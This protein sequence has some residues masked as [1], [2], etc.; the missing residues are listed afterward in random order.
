MGTEDKT[1]TNQNTNNPV[2]EIS[3]YQRNSATKNIAP[4]ARLSESQN[5]NVIIPRFGYHQS[6]L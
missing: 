4:P 5:N 6:A 2:F 1:K 3:S